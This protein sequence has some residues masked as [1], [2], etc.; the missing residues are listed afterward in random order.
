M[1]DLEEADSKS[2]KTDPETDSKCPVTKT[3]EKKNRQD[4]EVINLEEVTTT[5]NDWKTNR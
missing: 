2:E 5:K 1:I 3:I 4:Q